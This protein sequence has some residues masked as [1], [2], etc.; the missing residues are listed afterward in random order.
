MQMRF[1]T[2]TRRLP[3][4]Y[5]LLSAC[6]RAHGFQLSPFEFLF[7]TNG[8]DSVLHPHQ[9]G[10]PNVLERSL[11]DCGRSPLSR[12]FQHRQEFLSLLF[13]RSIEVK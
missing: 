9:Q 8:H 11:I 5:F 7:F 10:Q 6:F 2:P 4:R 3:A 1:A 12:V 13:K